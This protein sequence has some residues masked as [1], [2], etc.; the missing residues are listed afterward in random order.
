ML[1]RS[2]PFKE[3]EEVEIIFSKDKLW[4]D[5]NDGWSMVVLPDELS[6]LSDDEDVIL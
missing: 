3:S 4:Q 5:D 1:F 2:L 6:E